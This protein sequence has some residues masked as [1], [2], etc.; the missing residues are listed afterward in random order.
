V[1]YLGHPERLPE[2]KVKDAAAPSYPD[3]RP[4]LASFQVARADHEQPAASNPP[5]VTGQPSGTG[6][7]IIGR[8][9]IDRADTQGETSQP[10]AAPRDQKYTPTV[11][12]RVQYAQEEGARVHH[13]DPLS[14]IVNKVVM[15]P[16]AGTKDIA[17]V[18]DILT[19]GDQ[20]V[21]PLVVWYQRNVPGGKEL[22]FENLLVYFDN[23]WDSRVPAHFRIRLISVERERNEA[24][25]ELLNG[26]KT[27]AAGFQG[28]VPHPVMPGVD[29]GIE[30]ARQILSHKVNT[31]L[32]DYTVELYAATMEDEAGGADL[33]YLRTGQFVALG[34]S[35][36]GDA[37]VWRERHFFDQRTLRVYSEEN[38]RSLL[39]AEGKTTPPPDVARP[40][41]VAIDTQRHHEKTDRPRFHAPI[42][43][44]TVATAEAV[45]P[46][47]VQ[48]R[49]EELTKLLS[50]PPT[51]LDLDALASNI[52]SLESSV[53][54]F[55]AKR[56]LDREQT[57]DAMEEVV[58]LLKKH[59][60][61]SGNMVGEDGQL[62]VL[63]S[64]DLSQL[65]LTLERQTG[66]RGFS[67]VE[68]WL[69]WWNVMGGKKGGFEFNDKLQR[70]LWVTPDA[71]TTSPPSVP[72]G[73]GTDGADKK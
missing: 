19:R 38:L 69:K 15:P 25:L 65:M 58:D 48:D 64:V 32:M 14:I 47:I 24:T 66:L 49:S 17:V 21:Q 26:V 45:V 12:Q 7:G 11:E 71:R 57:K 13:N 2:S 54:V 62:H 40:Q 1:F 44:M 27:L 30:A 55:V 4:L 61:G 52:K 10:V 33:G 36:S 41:P 59:Q 50:Q 46:T 18:L 9:A 22:A 73:S 5:N 16:Y 42:V 31:M 35:R 63:S 23:A 20:R 3:V 37:E 70:K 8:Q 72:D 60:E 6:M 39:E 43:L 28:M 34:L 67:G 51:K 56:R 68:D 53:K 29:L